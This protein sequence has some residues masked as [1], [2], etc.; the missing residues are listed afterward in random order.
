M[1]TLSRN[2]KRVVVSVALAAFLLLPMTA[3]AATDFVDVADNNKFKDSIAWMAENG[4]TRGC[5]PP[6]NDR[7][8]PTANVTRQQ[9]AAFMH[10]LALLR[11]VD[12]GSVQGLTAAELQGQAGPQGQQGPPGADGIDGADG[13]RFDGTAVA[14][15]L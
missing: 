14:L 3:F 8:C 15:P 1:R 10:R 5:N 6:A 9:M 13:A 11:V 7:F 12:A 4:I 2:Q